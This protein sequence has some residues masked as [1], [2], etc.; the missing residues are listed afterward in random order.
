ME[1]G[2]IWGCWAVHAICALVFLV[3]R[4]G[5]VC[6]SARLATAPRNGDEDGG[7][8]E[9]LPGAKPV[10]CTST[11]A[12]TRGSGIGVAWVRGW[13]PGMP[14]QIVWGCVSRPSTSPACLTRS[15]AR[16]GGTPSAHLPTHTARGTAY[17]A[18]GRAKKPRCF[19]HEM[20]GVPTGMPLERSG[21]E[22]GGVPVYVCVRGGGALLLPTWTPCDVA[23]QPS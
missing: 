15:H 19:G 17:W 4:C 12:S 1:A 5:P 13:G 22:G 11:H 20:T 18:E 6:R 10:Q 14:T 16:E 3:C 9:T 23:P 21:A 7:W 8:V 2:V